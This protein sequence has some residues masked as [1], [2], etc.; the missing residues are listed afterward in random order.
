MAADVIV[1]TE[2]TDIIPITTTRVPKL[3]CNYGTVFNGKDCIGKISP[4]KSK[5]QL[6]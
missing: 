3:L 6:Y 5:I 2:T 1:P 4:F